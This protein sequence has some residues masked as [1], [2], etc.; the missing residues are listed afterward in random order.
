MP[1]RKA[2]WFTYLLNLPPLLRVLPLMRLKSDSRYTIADYIE[3]QVGRYGDRPFILFE[4]RT[5]SYRE[6]NAMANR[7]AHWA[8]SI[9]LR[10]GDTVGF[11]MTNRAE[12]VAGLERARESRRQGGA[13]QHQPE[14]AERPARSGRGRCEPPDRRRRMRG[15]SRRHRQRAIRRRGARDCGGWRRSRRLP[16]CRRH[17]HRPLPPTGVEPG[18]PASGGSPHRG[19]RLLHLHLRHD[20]PAQGGQVQPPEARA[21][22]HARPLAGAPQGAGCL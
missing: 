17:R 20:G 4:E 5:I 10:A 2:H 1:G 7:V 11:M 21:L 19:F 18:R 13:R 15:E 12:Y 16:R 9:G 3:G 6:F 14:G 22:R 8:L